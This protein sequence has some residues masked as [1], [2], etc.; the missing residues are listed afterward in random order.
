MLIAVNKMALLEMSVDETIEYLHRTKLPTLVVEGKNDKNM[1]RKLEATVRDSA[2]IDVLPVGGKGVVDAIYFRRTE[3]KP[4]SQVC[5]LRDRDLW[6]FGQVPE[7][8]EDAILTEGYSLENDVL[9]KSFISSL[10]GANA[11]QLMSDIDRVAHWFRCV[12]YAVLRK[13]V[14]DLDISRDVSQV[15]MHGAY[16]EEAEREVQEHQP[17]AEFIANC[18]DDNWVWLRGKTLF[19]TVLN[20]FKVSDTVYGRDQITDLCMRLHPTDAYSRLVATIVTKFGNQGVQLTQ[21]AMV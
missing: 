11:A 19:R 17:T 21:I 13:D 3:I 20:F 12:S 6:V 2:K 15:H 8:F 10:A 18:P 9:N 16:T 5:F 7:G 1:L 14:S 4:D